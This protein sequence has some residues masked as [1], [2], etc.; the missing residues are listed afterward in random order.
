MLTKKTAGPAEKRDLNKFLDDQK[1]Y[2]E[3]KEARQKERK[4]KMMLSE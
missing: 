4:E 3:M 1:K 2:L